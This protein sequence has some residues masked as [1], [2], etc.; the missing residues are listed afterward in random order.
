MKGERGSASLVMAAALGLAAI[1]SALSADVSR[2]ATARVRA[3]TAADAA[4][5]AAAQELVAP[6]STSPAQAAEQYAGRHGAAITECNCD[7]GS[8]EAL[9]TVELEVSLPFL[10]GERTVSA[11]A[12]AVVEASKMAGLVPAFAARLG[13]LFAKVPGLSIVSGFRTHAEQAALHEEKPALAAP[14]GHSMHELG[15]AADLG[16]PSDTARALAHSA[17]PSCGLE[18]PVSYE[19]WHI[20]PIGIHG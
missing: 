15:L 9:V 7:P 13:C 5:L 10:G 18:F 4:A 14:P 3:Q 6:S 17:A 20:E 11:E 8:D 16:F 2:V 19:P 12:R 1:L